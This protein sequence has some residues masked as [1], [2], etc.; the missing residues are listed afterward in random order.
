[1]ASSGVK[2]QARRLHIGRAGLR[3]FNGGSNRS[4]NATP[5]IDLVVEIEGRVKLP[6]PPFAADLLK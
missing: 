2:A 6:V 4:A 1:M 5:E 3:L